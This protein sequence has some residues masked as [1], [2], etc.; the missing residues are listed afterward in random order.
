MVNAVRSKDLQVYF[1]S[2]VAENLLRSYHLDAAIQAP[3]GDSLFVV[4]ANIAPNKANSFIVNP[5][6]YQV[7]IDSQGAAT[8]RTT[9]HYAWTIAGQNYGSPLY[10]DYVHV[11]VPPGSILLAQDGWQPRGTSNAFN[12]KV[13]MGYFTLSYGQTRTITLVWKVPAAASKVQSGWHYQYLVQRQA[14]ALWK[15]NLQIT[16]PSCA[17]ITN[18][19]EG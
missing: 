11:Y 4:D 1:N 15:L 18:K 5:L 8:H 17:V 14:G 13:W 16:L 6:N 10:R 7:T 9:L 19:G 2:A 3:T 12:R